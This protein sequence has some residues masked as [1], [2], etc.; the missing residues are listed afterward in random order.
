MKVH[1]AS[2]LLLLTFQLSCQKNREE[3][4]SDI[5]MLRPFSV[6]KKP[7]ISGLSIPWGMAFLNDSMLL[8]AE[9]NGDVLLGNVMTGDKKLLFKVPG[10]VLYG[11]G[12]LMDIRLHPS[13]KQNKLIYFTYTKQV[14][15]LYTTAVGR[16]TFENQ[17]F[18]NFQEVF[19]ADA[20]SSS[21]VHFGSRLAF[22]GQGHFYLGLGDRGNMQQAQN[23]K[24]HM[25]CIIRLRDDGSLPSDNPFVN[26]PDFLP[27]IWSYGH[28]NIQ[29]LD[30]NPL[31]KE[32]W[33]HEHGPQ[34]G[35]EINIIIKGAN[36]GWP[37][38]TY[39]EQYGGGKIGE[40][41]YPGT[42]QPVY[43]WTPS[44]APCGMAFITS[45]KYPGWRGHLVIGALAGQHVNRT[46]FS[47]SKLLSETRYFAGEGR[48]RNVV[49][50]T[51]GFIYFSDETHGIIYRLEPVFE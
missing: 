45:N 12:G 3:L 21:G 9:K 16:A 39:G 19:V 8:I 30:W 26:N 6:V 29:G 42:I 14:N 43:Y 17:A 41:T 15:G 48:I 38:A 18:N 37:L 10:A 46:S 33:A 50:S 20:L 25:G 28:R 32:L 2:L 5:D 51:D 7:V 22:D 23:T 49:E 24:N 35:D 4:P 31:T 40:P 1:Y 27:E 11:Q 36:Y 34:G 47:G 13:F 44:I